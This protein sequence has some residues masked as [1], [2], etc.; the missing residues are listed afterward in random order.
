MK[1]DHLWL[2]A[3]GQQGAAVF[4]ALSEPDLAD[5]A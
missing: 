4:L 3:G 5:D 2:V 1:G